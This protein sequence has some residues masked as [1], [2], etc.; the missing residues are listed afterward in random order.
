MTRLEVTRPLEAGL[1]SLVLA[2]SMKTP[3]RFLRSNEI[4]LPPSGVVTI[5]LELT[6]SLQ[7]S[8][9]PPPTLSVEAYVA[10]YYCPSTLG[11][12]SSLRPYAVSWV[13]YS[14]ICTVK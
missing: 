12:Y 7:V 14:V 10:T 8:K 9:V 4:L 11:K 6:F 1:G 2:A 5:P 3:H 13:N